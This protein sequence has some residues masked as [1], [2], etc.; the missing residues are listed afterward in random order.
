M[1][2][3]SSRLHTALIPLIYRAV[4][5]RA[6]SEWALN[7]LDVDSFFLHHG[8]PQAANHLQHIRHL[9]FYAPINLARFNRCAYYSIFRT[10]GL[11][12]CSSTL[13][14]SDNTVAHENFLDDITEQLRLVFSHLKPDSLRTFQC[15]KPI[16]FCLH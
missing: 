7:V 9:H 12:P 3:V 2:Q 11:S 5:F 1:S 6:T 8:R 10:A 15:V 13:G 16:T 4:T 14:T